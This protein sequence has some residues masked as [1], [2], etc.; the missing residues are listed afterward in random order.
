MLIR[1]H[2]PHILPSRNHP[3][4]ASPPGALIGIAGLASLDHYIA[5][6]LDT[7]LIAASFGATA[8]LLYAAP[9]VPLAQPINLGD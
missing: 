7:V 3:R 1:L 9:T 4:L 6:G 5:P 8:V 2:S